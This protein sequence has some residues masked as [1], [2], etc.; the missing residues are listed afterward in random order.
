MAKKSGLGKGLGALF[1]E[2]AVQE[3]SSESVLKSEGE[4][5]VNLKLVDIE[6]NRQQPRKQFDDEK[7]TE[8]SESIKEH[9]VISPILVTKSDNGFYKIIAGERRWRAAKKAGIKTIP[10][11]VKDFTSLEVQEIALVENLQRQDLNPVEEALGYKQLMDEFSLTQEQISSRIGKSRSS[12]ANSLRILN[13]PSDVIEL[14]KNGTISFGHAKVILSLESAEEQSELAKKIAE[15]GLSVRAAEQLLNEK[16]KKKKTA[17]KTDLN[18]R[19]AFS[20]IERAMSQSLG[21][22]VKIADRGNKGTIKIE[23]YS[24]EEL[25]RIT[26]ILNKT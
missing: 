22:K 16:P 23:Y 13:L 25:E 2:S 24:K 19:L 4:S 20:E 14:L 5:V 7:L 6:P 15:E 9:G 10:A 1:G 26:E 3:S 8:L 12:V 18:L 21:A 11:I 17:K